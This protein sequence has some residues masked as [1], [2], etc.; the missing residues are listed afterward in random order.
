MAERVKVESAYACLNCNPSYAADWPGVMSLYITVHREQIL[1]EGYFAQSNYS[2]IFTQQRL[3][4]IHQSMGVKML[5]SSD[6]RFDEYLH[7]RKHAQ[8]YN[9][10]SAGRAES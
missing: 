5:P 2:S 7:M 4:N 10:E 3:S 9:K 6:N 8:I 1:R